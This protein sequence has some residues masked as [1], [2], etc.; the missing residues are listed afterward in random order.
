[1][2]AHPSRNRKRRNSRPQQ[3]A[4]SLLP[5]DDRLG[6]LLAQMET[7]MLELQE[8][9]REN[10]ALRRQLEATR[11]FVHDP[12]TVPAAIP[13]RPAAPAA[14]DGTAPEDLPTAAT[15]VDGTDLAAAPVRVEDLMTDD[16]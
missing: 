12:Y 15:G 3:G 16:L 10:A 6:R 1:M 8:L 2:A 14:L 7:M 13:P 5:E 4:P 11:G 9:R